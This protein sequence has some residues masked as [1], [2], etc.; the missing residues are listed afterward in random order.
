VPDEVF[1]EEFRNVVGGS[2][3]QTRKNLREAQ[4]LLKEAGYYINNGKLVNSITN[5]PLVIDFL[6]SQMDMER[7]ISQFQINLKSIGIESNIRLV[8]T[9]QYQKRLDQ[10]DFDIIV[11]NFPQSLS[12]G[13]EQRDYWGSEAAQVEGSRNL[14]G[15]KNE[16][17]DTLI[18]KIIYSNYYVIPHYYAA[19]IRLARWNKFNFS[20][21]IP[22]YNMNLFTWWSN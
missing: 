1:N 3:Q 7:I 8:D 12:P 17:V 4:I 5:K 10:F 11:A 20:E 14:I 2:V 22:D 6:I 19:G 16:A 21:N 15:I 13:N 9:T 18:D